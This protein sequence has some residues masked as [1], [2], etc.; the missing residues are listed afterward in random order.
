MAAPE[1]VEFLIKDHGD[2]EPPSGYR[3]YFAEDRPYMSL[4]QRNGISLDD[5][6]EMFGWKDDNDAWVKE[7]DNKPNNVKELVKL[8]RRI[9]FAVCGWRELKEDFGRNDVSCLRD[10]RLPFVTSRTPLRAMKD[11]FNA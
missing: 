2:K 11:E 10:I 4:L 8:R 1:A 3:K 9:D 7:Y 6:L 5:L